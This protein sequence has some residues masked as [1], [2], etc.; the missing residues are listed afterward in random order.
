MADADS[1]WN[2]T[3]KVITAG[4]YRFRR[5]FRRSL[6]PARGA[7]SV[8]VEVDQAREIVRFEA[9]SPNEGSVDV[10]LGH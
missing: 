4:S 7:M 1:T 5:G 10:R 8:F 6:A 9:G 3:I 2:T